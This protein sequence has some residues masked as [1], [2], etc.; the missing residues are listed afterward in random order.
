MCHIHCSSCLWCHPFIYWVPRAF[1]PSDNLARG[2]IENWPHCRII[3]WGFDLPLSWPPPSKT[4]CFI[5]LQLLLTSHIPSSPTAS[6]SSQC[7]LICCQFHTSSLMCS[8]PHCAV[9]VAETWTV[10]SWTNYINSHCFNSVMTVVGVNLT[11]RLVHRTA[12]QCQMSMKFC[13]WNNIFE[14]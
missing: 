12:W 1:L 8:L 14:T 13:D 10:L 2:R 7:S 6:C 3:S 9:N 4:G 5:S 11:Y